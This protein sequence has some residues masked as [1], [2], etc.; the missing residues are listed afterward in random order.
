MV[1]R[2][3]HAAIDPSL[4]YGNEITDKEAMNELCGGWYFRAMGA[5]S[6]S[7]MTQGQALTTDPL[8]VLISVEPPQSHGSAGWSQLR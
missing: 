3:L 4:S 5:F 6:Y 2:Q 8:L 7:K 1:H